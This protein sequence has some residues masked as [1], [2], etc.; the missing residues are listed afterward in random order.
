MT[1]DGGV[2][3]SFGRH[4][5][6]TIAGHRHLF[7]VACCRSRRERHR[8]HSFRTAKTDDRR[9][10]HNEHGGLTLAQAEFDHHALPGMPRS[11]TSTGQVDEVLAVEDMPARIIAYH[12]HLT[13][14]ADKKDG[15]GARQDAAS[16]LSTIMKAL[17]TRTGHD[18]GEYKEKTLVRRLQR[19]MQLPSSTRR[20]PIGLLPS[21]RKN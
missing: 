11:A 19:R 12:S 10:C 13:T 6:D 21:N 14:V 16:H 8:N 17:R 5:P 18:F 7:Q 2:C 4:R 3:R 1:I 9:R 20:M 15:E